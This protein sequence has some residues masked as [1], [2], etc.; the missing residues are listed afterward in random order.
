MLYFEYHWNNVHILFVGAKKISL[1]CP[2][3]GGGNTFFTN[4]SYFAEGGGASRHAHVFGQLPLVDH[5][6]V[7]SLYHGFKISIHFLAFLLSAQ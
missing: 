2:L 3:R 6:V 7:S 4:V 5:F 1:S